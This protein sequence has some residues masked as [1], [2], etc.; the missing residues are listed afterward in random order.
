MLFL[1]AEPD[2][3]GAFVNVDD[4]DPIDIYFFA[5]NGA[6][7]DGLRIHCYPE[8]LRGPGEQLAAFKRL[9]DAFEWEIGEQWEQ[10]A[11]YVRLRVVPGR[12]RWDLGLEVAAED[13]MDN[14]SS[15]FSIPSRVPDLR[16]LGETL[17]DWS[18]NPSRPLQWR[19]DG[20]D[21]RAT[22]TSWIRPNPRAGLGPC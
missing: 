21:Y 14:T 2:L 17:V 13:H 20:Y 8:G 15:A 5:S 11:F 10:F 18:E 6:F 9:A 16:R 12:R 3:N 19:P 7:S 22:T 1:N 4:S